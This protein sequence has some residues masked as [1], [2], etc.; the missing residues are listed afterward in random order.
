MSLDLEALKALLM[1]R[2][3]ATQVEITDN[4]LAHSG[5]PGSMGNAHLKVRI[6]SPKF[7]GLAIIDQHRLV[8]AAIKGPMGALI[9]ALEITTQA[10]SPV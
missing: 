5:H 2:L 1:E 7:V 8:H 10:P 4:T 6:V 9:H 3:E